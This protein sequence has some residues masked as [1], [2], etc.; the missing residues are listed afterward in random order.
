MT[1]K[2]L[3]TAIVALLAAHSALAGVKIEHWG[4]KPWKTQIAMVK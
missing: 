3:L 2:K 4:K 1:M